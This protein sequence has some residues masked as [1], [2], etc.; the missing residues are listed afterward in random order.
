MVHFN[1]KRIEING[2]TIELP[3]SILDAEK[4]EQNI[5]VIFDY[6]EFNQSSIARN[7]QCLSQDG[8]VI[9]LAEN[10]TTQSCDAYVNF[11]GFDLVN[12][13][14]IANNFAGFKCYIELTTGKLLKSEFTK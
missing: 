7:L 14:V 10:P 9:W 4:F 3:Y 1:K 8:S 6:M 5:L 2:V 11:S 12:N 13:F